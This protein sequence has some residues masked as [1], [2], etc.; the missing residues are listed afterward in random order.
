MIMIMIIMVMIMIVII[1]VDS[2]RWGDYAPVWAASGYPADRWLRLAL[3]SVLWL[4]I[5]PPHVGIHLGEVIMV[6]S[7]LAEAAL[8]IANS[9]R[10]FRQPIGRRIQNLQT[11][12]P[13]QSIWQGI[14]PK[15]L[16]S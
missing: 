7:E 11:R 5:H 4:L 6:Q 14:F 16:G 15:E 10:H 13:A 3:F 2:P 1:I 8:Q 12:Q 9:L